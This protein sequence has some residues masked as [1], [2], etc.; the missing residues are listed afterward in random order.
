MTGM[1]D[2]TNTTATG[3]AIVR[4]AAI[5]LLGPSLALKSQVEVECAYQILEHVQ[6]H[7]V[8][9]RL[10][11]LLGK[12]SRIEAEHFRKCN[13]RQDIEIV[14][15]AGSWMPRTDMEIRNDFMAYVTAGGIPLGFANPQIPQEIRDR[16]SVLFRMPIDL[17]KLQPDVR[18]AFMRLEQLRELVRVLTERQ[19]INP[20]TV[21][22]SVIEMLVSEIPVD[23]YIDDHAT[24]ANT[25]RSW[26]K[27]DE[28]LFASPVEAEA[29]RLL[30]IQHEDAIKQLQMD[31]AED[32]GEVQEV[33][34]A[35]QGNAIAVAEEA[36]AGPQ[37]PPP[38][39][40]AAS[41]DNVSGDDLAGRGD[42]VL[43]GAGL[44]PAAGPRA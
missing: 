40:P 39:V 34:A 16:A 33:Q 30:V 3:M 44:A 5:A 13:I 15:E 29:V 38:L 9:G 43:P 23:L 32:A 24:M 7:W 10:S 36:A 19:I 21:D 26:L 1:V 20:T 2:P 42:S 41:S 4:D 14:A 35:A 28:G 17:D 25:Y 12:F 37:E 31:S 18:I 8:E 11:G 22:P 27:T 6:Q